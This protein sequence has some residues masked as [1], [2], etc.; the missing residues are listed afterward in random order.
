MNKKLVL[1]AMMLVFS[2]LGCSGDEG[3]RGI[4]GVMGPSGM[5]GI[6]GADG[7][8]GSDG[9]PGTAGTV[10]PTGADG[11]TGPQGMAGADGADATHG[12]S[13]GLLNLKDIEKYCKGRIPATPPETD[14]GFLCVG[15]S[16]DYF[17]DI[18]KMCTSAGSKGIKCV[19]GAGADLSEFAYRC[20]T[21]KGG[22]VKCK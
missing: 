15:G 3:E 21:N 10:G 9:P 22:N 2:I 1:I 19:H 16:D 6:T 4:D 18:E 14:K 20:H 8:S 13:T 12:V 17:R 11:S 5:A 7:S